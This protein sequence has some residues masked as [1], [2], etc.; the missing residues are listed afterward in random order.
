[1]KGLLKTV[2]LALAT[3]GINMAVPAHAQTGNFPDHPIRIVVP[4][5]PGGSTDIMAR[6]VGE[7]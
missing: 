5:A 7:G 2:F 3:L 6:M 4:F 1:M